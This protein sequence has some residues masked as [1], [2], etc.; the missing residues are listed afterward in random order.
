MIKLNKSLAKLE[1]EFTPVEVQI[2]RAIEATG[3]RHLR[4]TGLERT[5]VHK[6]QDLNG[7]VY[8]TYTTGYVRKLWKFGGKFSRG[9]THMTPISKNFVLNEEHRLLMIL[10]VARK[11][12]KIKNKKYSINE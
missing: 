3:F 7:D 2:V 8:A 5:S 9:T 4:K 1:Q 11:Q 6:F 12:L 10:R